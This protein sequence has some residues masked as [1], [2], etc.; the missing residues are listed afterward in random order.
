MQ[1]FTVHELLAE[2][3]AGLDR[4][5]PVAAH[6]AQALGALI[7]DIRPEH[8]R[9]REGIVAGS[10]HIPLTVLEWAVDPA[11]GVANPA[12]GDLDRQLIVMCNEGFSSS[13]AAASLQRLGFRRAT[14]LAGGFRAWRSAGLEVVAA[15][16]VDHDDGSLDGRRPPDG[17]PRS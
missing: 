5:E 1:R 13:L 6:Q 11:S 8:N 7:I 9:Q 10:L 14:D 15:P 3:R 17:G 16:S 2:A 12:V 4:L